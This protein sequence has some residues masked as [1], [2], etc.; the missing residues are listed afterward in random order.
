MRYLK[1]FLSICTILLVKFPSFR[2]ILL[3]Q[4]LI[5]LSNMKIH[6]SDIQNWHFSSYNFKKQLKIAKN[7]ISEKKSKSTHFPGKNC[8]L[9][10]LI[11]KLILQTWRHTEQTALSFILMRKFATKN[12]PD[13]TSIKYKEN[14]LTSFDSKIFILKDSSIFKSF[15]QECILLC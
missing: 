7:Q 2:N 5:E 10:C 15:D 11:E 8:S 12:S 14:F 3:F 6:N 9:I 13:K 4:W 1:V